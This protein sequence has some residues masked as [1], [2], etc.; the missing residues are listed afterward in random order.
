L[1]VDFPLKENFII[2]AHGSLALMITHPIVNLGPRRY[3]KI[4]E[5]VDNTVVPSTSLQVSSARFTRVVMNQ[6]LLNPHLV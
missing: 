6:D 2:L 3:H 1:L 5:R 4:T